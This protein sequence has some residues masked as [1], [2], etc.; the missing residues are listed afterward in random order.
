MKKYKF[1]FVI[2][3]YKNVH[4]TLNCIASI[5]E[6]L[7]IKDYLIIVVDN[8]STNGTGELLKQK[9][10]NNEHVHIIL[11]AENLGFARGNNVGF[12]YAKAQ[13]SDFICVINSD[14]YLI[15]NDFAESIIQ[16]YETYRFYVLGPNIIEPYKE[17]QSNPMGNHVITYPEMRKRV[18][19]LRI[20]IAFHLLRGDTLASY[21]RKV[22]HKKSSEN[23]F[24]RSSYY[25]NVELHGCCLIFSPKYVA[26]YDGLNDCTFLYMEED[27]LYYEMMRKGYLTLYSPN[28]KIFHVGGASAQTK[29]LR[30]HKLFALRQ[31]LNSA[32]AIR[33]YMRKQD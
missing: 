18:F 27:L 21:I 23:A 16:D 8:G 31:H 2:L 5:E 25:E 24:D 22:R 6:R 4:E 30:K 13:G 20:Q 1:A 7:D 14:T 11:N 32:K 9:Y 15:T 28:V 19:S 17:A 33:N 29:K 12:R 10:V 3:H 26:E